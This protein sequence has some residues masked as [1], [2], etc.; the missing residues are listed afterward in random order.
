MWVFCVLKSICDAG[1]AGE[2]ICFTGQATKSQERRHYEAQHIFT[3]SED[4][5]T[6]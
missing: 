3:H 5:L 2:G 6:A 1:E 4:S